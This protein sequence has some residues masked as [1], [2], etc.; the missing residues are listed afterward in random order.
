VAPPDQH[1]LIDE[2]HIKLSVGPK[3]N[4]QRPAINTLFHSAA[5]AYGPWVIG[6]ILTDVLDDGSA[7]LWE[8]KQRGGLRRGCGSGA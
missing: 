3:E 8:I 2:G 5:F 4:R 6:V 7:G 1:Q